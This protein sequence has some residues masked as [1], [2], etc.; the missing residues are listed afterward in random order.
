MFQVSYVGNVIG[1]IVADNKTT[2]QRA[3]KLVDIK[4]EDIKPAIISLEVNTPV[5][6]L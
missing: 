6:H 5:L 3:A 2:A 4:Y 1:V